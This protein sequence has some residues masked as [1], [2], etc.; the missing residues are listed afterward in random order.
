MKDKKWRL[1]VYSFFDHTGI[2]RHLEKMAE[3]GWMIY[4]ITGWGWFY[5]RIPPA[6]WKF[7]VHY[8]PDRSEFDSGPSEQEASFYDLCAHTGWQLACA[9]AQMQIFCTQDPHP[10]PMD[11]DPALEVE[12]IHRA[13][14][15]TMLP[16][17]FSML[18]L[19]LLN[20]G[21]FLSRLLGDPIGLLSSTSALFSGFAY[22]LLF[23]LC[24]VELVGYFSWRAKAKKAAQ[25]GEFFEA[26]GHS[27]FQWFVLYAVLLGA[28]C[29]LAETLILGDALARWA[30]GFMV[31]YMVLMLGLVN[32]VKS[33]LKRK[34]ASRRLNRTMTIVLAFCLGFGLMG[35]FTALTL[36]MWDQGWFQ[37]DL[38]QTDLPLTLEDL[39]DAP[40]TG[41]MKRHTATDSFL[42]GQKSL[43]QYPSAQL[44]A[45]EDEGSLEYTVTFVKAPFL[46]DFC[47][48]RLLSSG[49]AAYTPVPEQLRNRYIPADPLPWQAQEAYQLTE[50][51]YGPTQTY[52]LCYQTHFVE[53]QFSWVPTAQQMEA[54]SAALGSL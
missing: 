51:P 14:K 8:F 53:I 52:L 44:G 46:Y 6:Q 2:A 54:V 17:Y 50:V 9:S 11:T 18:V 39:V 16:I 41:Y 1:E 7:T 35:G 23:L 20:G 29:W 33:F 49:E 25:R 26:S 47:K 48:E 22:T 31:L 3:K 37:E 15:R 34:K 10:I 40:L 24:V 45:T 4:K 13:A 30:A 43:G 27:W 21:L 36:R 32:T 38:Q 12:T 42:L 19:S 28:L 5:R